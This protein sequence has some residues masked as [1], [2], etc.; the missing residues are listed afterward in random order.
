MS[1]HLRHL[2]PGY[3]KGTPGLGLVETARHPDNGRKKIVFLTAKGRDLI[4]K[5]D[6]LLVGPG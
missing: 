4:A 5:I 2:G 1:Q 3:R 6:R